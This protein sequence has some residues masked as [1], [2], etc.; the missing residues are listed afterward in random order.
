MGVRSEGA[1]LGAKNWVL[2]GGQ[3]I[4]YGNFFIIGGGG[5]RQTLERVGAN[6]FV[7][8]VILSTIFKNY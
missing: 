4:F 7:E 5:G 6:I 2:S 8:G 3:N 1:R